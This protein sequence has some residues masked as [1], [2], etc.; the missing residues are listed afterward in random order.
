MEQRQQKRTEEG[1]ENLRSQAAL[2]CKYCGCKT[3]EDIIKAALWSGRG[4][5]VIEDIPAWLCDGCGEQFFDEQVIQRI[6]RV[7]TYPPVQAKQQI[8]VLVYSLPH[9]KV[10]KDGC[11]PEVPEQ[12]HIASLKATNHQAKQATG[13]IRAN[14]DRQE[15]FLCNYCQSE[16]VEDLVKSAFWVDGGLIAVENIPARV[17]RQ[18]RQQFYEHE[19]TEK[20]TS[21]E[22]RKFAAAMAKREV[23]VPVFSLADVEGSISKRDRQIVESGR[24]DQ[25]AAIDIQDSRI[26]P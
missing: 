21:L 20:L 5:I 2:L 11:R 18:C 22:K 25:N 15:T 13:I 26:V 8:R 12:Q 1:R 24:L 23:S 16:T 4:L 7:I 14:Q 19:T 6:Q 3:N 9:V 17:C 10:H